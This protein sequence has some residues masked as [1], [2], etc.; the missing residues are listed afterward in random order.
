MVSFAGQQALNAQGACSKVV[1]MGNIL[2]GHFRKF[3]L[4]VSHDLAEPAVDPLKSHVG[5]GDGHADG[6][7]FEDAPEARLAFPQSLFG[8]FLFRDVGRYRKRGNDLCF[9]AQ[10]TGAYRARE[11]ALSGPSFE[12]KRAGISLE[13]I[14]RH[15]E[16]LAII[17][18][19]SG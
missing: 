7:V 9:I 8:K 1:G 12:F 17:F 18:D 16:S 14:L 10:R 15:P 6:R 3:P 5:R 2:K 13:Y 19:T 4:R 11:D